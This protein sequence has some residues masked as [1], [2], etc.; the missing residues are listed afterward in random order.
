MV[1]IFQFYNYIYNRSINVFRGC[2]KEGVHNT[3]ILYSTDLL[4]NLG[5]GLHRFNFS[6]FLFFTADCQLGNNGL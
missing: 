5:L 6:V 3:F 2:S 4:Q 1:Q